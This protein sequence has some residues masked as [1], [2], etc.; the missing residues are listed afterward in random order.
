[1]TALF[2][3]YQETCLRSMSEGLQLHQ[4][5]LKAVAPRLEKQDKVTELLADIRDLVIQVN[6]VGEI[7]QITG[8][9]PKSLACFTFSAF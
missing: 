2:L 8:S 5:L 4:A 1:M 9:Q 3:C 6:K 7:L